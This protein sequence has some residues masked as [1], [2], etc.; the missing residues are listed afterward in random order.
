MKSTRTRKKASTA[1][2]EKSKADKMALPNQSGKTDAKQS[3]KTVAAD[4]MA[5]PDQSGKTVAKQS[6]KTDAADKMA[7]PDQSGKTDAKQSGKTVA[8]DKMALPDQSGATDKTGSINS[9]DKTGSSDRSG[10]KE[11]MDKTETIKKP[12]KEHA[13]NLKALL[14]LSKPWWRKFLAA[15]FCMLLVNVA[16]LMKPWLLKVVIDDFLVQNKPQTFWYSLS[17]MAILYFAVSLVSGLFAWLQVNLV[18]RAGQAIIHNLR[19]KVFDTILHLPL[20][21]L[22][23]N[24]SGR[25]ITR[26]TNDI[27]E[28]GEFYTDITVNMLKDIIL[29]IGIISAMLIMDVRLS[30][31]SLAVIPVMGIMVWLIKNKIRK[32]FFHMKHFIGRLNGFIAESLTGMKTIQALRIE[33]AREKDF[34]ELNDEYFKT[35]LTQ[36]RL[37]SLLKPASDVFQNL[38]IS[39]LLAYGI[40]QV[41]GEMLPIGVLFAFTTYIRQ[42]FGPIS[43]LADKYNSIQSALVSAER[44]FDLLDEE[45]ILEKPDAGDD[46]PTAEGMI[47]FKNVWF[48]YI[49]ED[50]VLKNVSFT[51]KAGEIAAFVGETGAGKTTI[52]S[53]VSGFYDAQKG[54]I[55]LDGK[56]I[57]TMKKSDLRRRVATVF[58]DVFLFAGNIRDNITLHDNTPDHLLSTAIKAS[59]TDILIDRLPGGIEEEVTE[60][61]STLSAGQRQLVSFARAVAH[62]PAVLVMD[63]ATANID[64]QTERLIQS[65]LASVTRDRTTL[66]IAHRLS[67]IRHADRIF[68]MKH[69]EI[70]EEG[71]HQSL[72]QQQGYYYQLVSE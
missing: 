6:G 45:P 64:T 36:I 28:I 25:L 35:T 2:S 61:G 54:D 37:N 16:V 51:V 71:N 68:V 72:L 17:T 50:W 39:L 30:L 47:E 40:R 7:L 31:V 29:L 44:V 58:Q 12:L 33:K 32:N 59:C 27:S 49:E 57:R 20:P 5:L 24:S 22:D 21:W 41:S 13:G 60:R 55:L 8:A 19:C 3:G 69:G 65:A 43:D 9:M 53:L 70:I 34:T 63:E 26:A 48:A 23:K 46:V 56:S 62:D 10:K 1:Y 52:M 42:F 67:T 14:L 66:M 4:K 38:S 18:N 11:K 15:I